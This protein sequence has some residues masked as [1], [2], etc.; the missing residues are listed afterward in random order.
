MVKWAE[1]IIRKPDLVAVPT[2]SEKVYQILAGGLND[3][4][5]QNDIRIIHR[6]F[7]QKKCIPTTSGM[8]IPK[9]AYFKD[10]RNLFPDLPMI[11]FQDFNSSVGKLMELLGIRKV[12][13]FFSTFK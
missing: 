13:K 3:N 4:I 5:S 10:I 7:E 1:F 2:F 12:T 9:E 11:K 8:K 6:L